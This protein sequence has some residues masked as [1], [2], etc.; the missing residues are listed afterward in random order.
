MKRPNGLSLMLA[1]IS[2]AMVGCPKSEDQ[3]TNPPSDTNLLT[4]S[5]FEVSGGASLQGWMVNTTDTAFVNF[6]TDTP[7]GGGSFSVRLRNEWSFPGS[8]WQTV[9]LPSGTHRYRLTALAKVV[10]AAMNAGGDMRIQIKQAGTWSTTKNFHFSDTTWTS[11]SLLDT[12]TTVA[13]DT[14]AVRLRGNIDQFSFGYVLFD[15]L[16][17]ESLD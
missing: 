13:G 7:S 9:A 10:R 3:I 8:V 15:L 17:L 14:I 11:A 5:S 2:L 4:N 16:K 6:S 1:G 12:L